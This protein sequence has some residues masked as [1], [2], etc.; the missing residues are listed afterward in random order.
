MAFGRCHPWR[1]HQVARGHRLFQKGAQ[2]ASE[3]GVQNLIRQQR[4]TLRF[5]EASLGIQAASGHET[6]HVRMNTHGASP[7]MQRRNDAGFGTEILWI[8]EELFEGLPCSGHQPGSKECA[9][10]LPE[11]I[12]LFGNGE[13]D[14]SVITREQVGR[15]F[16]QPVSSATTAALR[17]GAMSAGVEFDPGQLATVTRFEMGT[18][19]FCA[20]TQLRGGQQPRCPV[21]SGGF[22]FCWELGKSVSLGSGPAGPTQSQV[23]RPAGQR[24]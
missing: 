7:C 21:V 18:E 23:C 15:C 5:D 12:E 8:G 6:M 20:A 11:H 13:D 4:R 10:E 1:N 16:L 2:F 24:C 3:F 19:L 14:V 17:T 9:I 22:A